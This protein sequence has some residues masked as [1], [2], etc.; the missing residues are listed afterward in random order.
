M[1]H[2]IQQ[3]LLAITCLVFASLAQASHCYNYTVEG[4]YNLLVE[5]GD[6]FLQE[7]IKDS[8]KVSYVSQDKELL[9]G[10]NGQD[11]RVISDDGKYIL[12]LTD[13]MY[14]LVPKSLYTVKEYGV[15]PL[16]LEDEVNKIVS[17]Q[18]YL[19]SG[20]WYYVVLAYNGQSIKHKIPELKGNLEIIANFNRG[21]ILLKD[22]HAVYIYYE[23]ENRLNEIP[24]LS[25]S[26]THF[27]QSP[28]FYQQHHYLYDDDT[29]YLINIRFIYQD[30]TKQFN[31]QGKRDGFTNAEI[32]PSYS[33]D[34]IDTKDGL[35]WLYA[36]RT[37][38]QGGD[39]FFTPVQATYLNKY[40][41][42]YVYHDKVYADNWDLIQERQPLDLAVVKNPEELHRPVTVVFSDNV[43]E[44]LYHEHQLQP[45]EKKINLKTTEDYIEIQNQR[46]F[47]GADELSSDIS[48]DKPIFLGSIVN[49]IK[50]CDSR[51]GDSVVVDYYYFFTDGNK[52]YA[53][54]NPSVKKTPQ[55][56]NNISP[57]DLKADDYDTLQKL[58]N[59]LITP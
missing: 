57:Q 35:L 21:E 38:P 51:M 9:K 29:F 37:V 40:K 46:I 3:T 28:N 12:F 25:P 56:L 19:V 43:L 13:A 10:V 39:S 32:H 15:N 34:S 20:D 1:K 53:Y 44:Y 8:N 5:N 58:M 55:I 33:G 41:D 24:H 18:F 23:G 54:V 4:Y 17:N 50:P 30:I 47:I 31:L 7:T 36:H 42:V 22:D 59:M 48:K 45:Q 49:V 11:F 26:Q 14:Y 52:V 6:M 16:F 2:L 27:V